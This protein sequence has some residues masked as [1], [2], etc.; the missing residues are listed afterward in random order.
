MNVTIQKAERNEST[1]VW[2]WVTYGDVVSPLSIGDSL[3]NDSVTSYTLMLYFSGA[4][5]VD[6]PSLTPGTIVQITID[7]K[8]YQYV[9]VDGGRIERSGIAQYCYHSYTIQP[10]EC[11]FRDIY[12]QTSYFSAN[13]YTL[14]QFFTRLIALTKTYIPITISTSFAYSEALANWV[15]QSYQVRSNAFLDNIIAIGDM[16]GVKFKAVFSISAGA[17]SFTLQLLSLKGASTISSINGDLAGKSDDYKGATFAGKAIG[18]TKNLLTNTFNWYPSD[19]KS[20]GFL[21]EPDNDDDTITADN[22]VVNLGMPIDHASKVR[23]V[24]FGNVITNSATPEDGTDYRYYD[25][26]GNQ[27]TPETGKYCY[28]KDDALNRNSMYI[29]TELKV[30]EYNE[31]LQLDSDNTGGATYH[32]QNTLYYKEGESK[33]YN[34]K[35]CEGSTS[36]QIYTRKVWSGGVAISTTY[37]TQKLRYH[38]NYYIVQATGYSDPVIASRNA[39]NLLD[40]VTIYS[41]SENV[42]SGS[43]FIKNINGH[44]ESMANEELSMTYDFESIDDVPGVGQKYNG[45]VLSNVGIRINGSK[46]QAA[47]ILSDSIVTKSEYINADAGVVLPS[48]PFAKAYARETNYETRMYICRNLA[49]AQDLKA[50]NNV[51]IY[52]SD[53]YLNYLFEAFKNDRTMYPASIIEAKI[54]TGE[55]TVEYLYSASP[56]QVYTIDNSLFVNLKINHASVIGKIADTSIGTAVSDVRY[57]PI[58]YVDAATRK[59]KALRIKF[60]T[61]SARGSALNY[62]R[63]SST[64]YNSLGSVI[65]ITDNIHYHDPAELLNLTYQLTIKNDLPQYKVTNVFFQESNLFKDTFST[66]DIYT[67]Y[68]EIAGVG[69]FRIESVAVENVEYK[70]YA[71]KLFI[72]NYALTV[73][74]TTEIRCYRKEGSN[75]EDMLT[76]IA[77]IDYNSGTGQRCVKIYIL[78]SN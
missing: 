7:S 14:P 34:I 48:I 10:I 20:I 1:W 67:R 16:L 44:I 27:I 55:S 51:N 77:S 25:M 59:T 24:G 73:D 68:V 26:N 8:V 36:T 69:S 12:I 63:I 38:L 42:I 6:K 40:R 60:S 37:K 76:S 13:E 23:V 65:D 35:I 54:R 43:A 53:T 4:V 11:Y 3:K 75:E 17:A 78:I 19:H 18:H 41:Q 52:F 31:W 46:I 29:A 66:A 39:L 30:Y 72:D 74:S 64:D 49:T 15:N 61:I 62:P 33:I 2:S 57:Y 58:T 22:A 28:F 50:K 21:P 32:Q 70:I 71:L 56:V 9:I 45:M 5:G 47:I